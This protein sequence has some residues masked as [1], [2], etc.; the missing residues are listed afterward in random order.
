MGGQWLP[1]DSGLMATGCN[2]INDEKSGYKVA[3][4]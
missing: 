2:D 1:Q 3:T 4:C